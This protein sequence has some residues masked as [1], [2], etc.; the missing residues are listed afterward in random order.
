MHRGTAQGQGVTRIG[1]DN[2]FMA[3]SHVAHDCVVGDHAIF[4][5]SASLSG[6]CTVG[7]YV[8]F[9]GFAIT[10]Q[11]CRVGAHAFL[12]LG[13]VLFQDVPPYV[14]VSGNPARPHGLN[15][16]GLR[17]RGFTPEEMTHLKQAY[18]LLYRSGLSLDMALD[19]IAALA[20]EDARIAVLERFVR[21]GG[22]Q[23]G[24]AR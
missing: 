5:N 23:R 1:S 8:I 6:H 10:H 20:P 16:E 7:D 15:A 22:H 19:R 18:R 2:L 11:F 3:Y 17:R 24:L 13:T 14:T 9:G 12:A 4:A 21:E